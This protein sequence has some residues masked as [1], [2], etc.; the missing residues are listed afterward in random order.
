ML[1]QQHSCGLFLGNPRTR[2]SSYYVLSSSYSKP[3][4]YQSCHHLKKIKQI[5]NFPFYALDKIQQERCGSNNVIESNQIYLGNIL[6]S[7]IAIWLASQSGHLS[8]VNKFQRT[9]ISWELEAAATP[10][11]HSYSRSQANV[12]TSL[13]SMQCL[14]L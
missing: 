8:L 5:A 13:V 7:Y 10:G 12:L 4:S 9:S 6:Y 2:L 11:A 14:H 1:G 3:V